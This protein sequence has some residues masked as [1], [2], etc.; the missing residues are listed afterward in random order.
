MVYINDIVCLFALFPNFLMI[1][2][3]TDFSNSNISLF[4]SNQTIILCKK[5][6]F[7]FN[8]LSVDE[9]LCRHYL[10]HSADITQLMNELFR[11]S[12]KIIHF[13]KRV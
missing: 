2:Q 5:F 13:G 4:D 11:T 3:L 6:P 10:N 1:L 8:D 9:V 7:P 12:C